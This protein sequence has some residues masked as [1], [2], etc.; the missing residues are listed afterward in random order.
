MDKFQELLSDNGTQ[1]FGIG[2]GEPADHGPSALSRNGHT[3]L[4][5]V[6]C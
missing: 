4:I 5:N 3:T 1:V 6:E 2:P